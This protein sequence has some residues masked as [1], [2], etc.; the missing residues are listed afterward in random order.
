MLCIVESLQDKTRA[1]VWA[2]IQLPYLMRVR[3]FDASLWVLCEWSIA[4][5]VSIENRKDWNRSWR[6]LLKLTF[7]HGTARLKGPVV[8]FHVQQAP[9]HW[10]GFSG[11]TRG[12]D[13]LE[14][15]I[16]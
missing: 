14:I 5:S 4:E 8:E 15:T 16:P 13:T 7:R 9:C 12:R 3:A 10:K 2:K 11:E 1:P 6:K